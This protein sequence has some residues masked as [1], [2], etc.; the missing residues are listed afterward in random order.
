MPG[1]RAEVVLQ[2]GG[3]LPSAISHYTSAPAL[4]RSRGKTVDP[5]SF[6]TKLACVGAGLAGGALCGPAC[7]IGAHVL[8]DLVTEEG[9]A[10]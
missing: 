6:W 4:R 5:Q 3:S 7:G 8:C 2:V 10:R 1:F 9:V